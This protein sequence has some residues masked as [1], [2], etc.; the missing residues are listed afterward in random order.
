MSGDCIRSGPLSFRLH[1]QERKERARRLEQV[2]PDGRV[3]VP[4]SLDGRKDEFRAFA[5]TLAAGIPGALVYE[6]PK[7]WNVGDAMGLS[8]SDAV[9]AL[10]VRVAA[11]KALPF[12]L[13]VPRATTR[14]AMAEADAM[15]RASRARF[16]AGADLLK[17]LEAAGGR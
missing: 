8:V 1:E 12:A 11:E 7:Q 2:E 9:R 5:E 6:T 4:W 17:S 14:T 10:L 16:A 15:A 13:R 3:Q